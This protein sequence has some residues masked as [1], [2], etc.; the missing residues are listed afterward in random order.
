MGLLVNE[1][2]LSMTRFTLTSNGV[3]LPEF[4]SL[5]MTLLLTEQRSHAVLCRYNTQT[6]GWPSSS[7]SCVLN[8]SSHTC[9]LTP[10]VM[11]YSSSS[12]HDLS[13]CNITC[14]DGRSLLLKI[15]MYMFDFYLT[16]F[17]Q[18]LIFHVAMFCCLL[19]SPSPQVS[20]PAR[21]VPSVSICIVWS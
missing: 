12:D 19:L 16:F 3:T 20:G 11:D 9:L 15:Y 21:T 8:G 5:S 2:H 6:T 14:G 4:L 18:Q 7:Y 1:P 17:S 10:L 13:V